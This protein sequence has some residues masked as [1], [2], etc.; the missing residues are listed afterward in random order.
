MHRSQEFKLLAECANGYISECACCHDLNFAYKNI[1]LG[2]PEEEMFR[3]LDWV[4]GVRFEP[5]SYRPLP[6]HRDRVY[7]SPLS[8]LFLAFNEAEL[9]EIEL[10][11][12][13]TRIMLET[14]RLIAFRGNANQ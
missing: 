9:E 6:H 7:P 11:A 2:F 12:E 3:F 4:I 5:E 14:R 10:L 13:Q 1:L 8:N